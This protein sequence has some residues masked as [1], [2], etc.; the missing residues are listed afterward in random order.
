[1]KSLLLSLAMVMFTAYLAA[2]STRDLGA[3]IIEDNAALG[4]SPGEIHVTASGIISEGEVSLSVGHD[5]VCD[6][7]QITISLNPGSYLYQS[8]HTRIKNCIIS[9]TS[10][11]I[12]GEI[13]SVNT[14]HV[15][16]DNVTFTGGGNLVFWWGV[17]HFRVLNNTVL[18]I[19]AVDDTT[20]TVMSGIYLKNC[21]HG[22]ITN[23]RAHDFVF[24]AGSDS[25]AVLTLNLSSY[26]TISNTDIENVDASYVRF[27][28]PAITIA[29][30]EYITVRGGLIAHNSNMDG[31]LSTLYVYT[32]SHD[33]T[34]TG[35]NS[36]YNGAQGINP[37]PF[38]TSVLGDGI[39]LM[40]TRH[41]YISHCILRGAGYPENRQPAIWIFIDDDVVVA[42]SDMSDGSSEGIEIAGSPKVRL[43]RN[44]INRNQRS[45]VYVEWQAGTATNVG[46]AVTFA[47][48][49]T[50]GFGLSWESGTPLILDG[51]TYQIASVSDSEHLTLATSPPDHFSPVP[52]GVNS[53]VDIIG[54]LIA[55]NGLLQM[56]GHEQVGINFADGTTG[57]ISGVTVTDTGVGAQLYGLELAND[58]TAYLSG[59]NFSGNL[60]GGNGVDSKSQE[61]SQST[62]FFPNQ[63]VAAKSSEQTFTFTAGAVA[64]QNLRIQSTGDFVPTNGCSTNLPPY[65][66]CEIRV[67]FTPSVVGARNG[68]ITITD[69]APNSPQTVSLAGTGLSFGLG[70]VV[71]SG[72]SSSAT[73]APGETANYQLSIGGAGVSGTASLSCIV[74]A[75]GA[76]C[77]V[78]GTQAVSATNARYLT[79]NV[80]TT[81]LTRGAVGRDDFH[82]WAWAIVLM[83]WVVLPRKRRT[84]QPA[85][86]H[87]LLPLLLLMSLCSCGGRDSKSL[88]KYILVVRARL[89]GI[90]AQIP[91]TLTVR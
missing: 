67:T 81:S 48:G 10:T 74:A 38:L 89:G 13:Q 2:G 15:E 78:I 44:S 43:L 56:G 87:A 66:T 34:I 86:R 36:S 61:V 46:P 5:L 32:P 19:T 57:T 12:D 53:S 22:Q 62:I 73:V 65:G 68:S 17:T 49:A 54:G 69:D 27:G 14:D 60:D 9:S 80:T 63:L 11:P 45:G 33:L 71:P 41:V 85:R 26:I 23:L 39:D 84:R 7:D 31:I 88:E 20:G 51:I 59:D 47:D 52:W 75:R 6:T 37:Q 76:T 40:N 83:G 50:G 82:P 64:V 21:S 90:S 55:D 72:S 8:S 70:F 3:Q 4:S 77:N 35:V 28:A 29:G 30:S 24:P 16:L 58:A 79:V 91:L 1:M 42:D 18:S 25:S